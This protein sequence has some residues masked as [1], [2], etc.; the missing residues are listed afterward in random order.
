[1]SKRATSTTSGT[2]QRRRLGVL[3]T[4]AGKRVELLKAFRSAA[5]RLNAS[6]LRREEEDSV[7]DVCIGLEA[8]FVGKERG[9][10][11]HKLATR[12]ATLWAA[13]PKAGLSPYEAFSATKSLYDYRSAVVHG[14]RKAE[15]KRIIK[16]RPGVEREPFQP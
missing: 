8:L 7:I 2:K 9:E 13:E 4:C 1:M 5:K 6:Y 15:R 14:S 12:L 16:P 10:I 3:F 11:T